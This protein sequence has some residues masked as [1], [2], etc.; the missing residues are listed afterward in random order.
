MIIQIV[1]II[2]ILLQ[3][4]DKIA[5]L[6]LAV[7]IKKVADLIKNCFFACFGINSIQNRSQ[8]T[9]SVKLFP[10]IPDYFKIQI[11]QQFIGHIPTGYIED[12]CNRRICI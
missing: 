8:I 3:C 4:V 9:V 1:E 2:T 5:A 12:R 6:H 7:S 11:W 10:G